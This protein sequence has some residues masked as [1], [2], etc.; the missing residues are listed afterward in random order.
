MAKDP[1]V[2][3]IECDCYIRA[4]VSLSLRMSWSPGEEESLSGSDVSARCRQSTSIEETAGSSAMNA[5]I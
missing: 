1:A 3:S 2:S 4:D 5:M